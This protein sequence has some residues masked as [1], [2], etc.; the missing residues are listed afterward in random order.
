MWIIYR[1]PDKSEQS[2]LECITNFIASGLST[3][4]TLSPPPQMFQQ[5]ALE[6]QSLY[7]ETWSLI[8]TC[9]IDLESE[10]YYIC[11]GWYITNFSFCFSNWCNN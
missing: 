1:S 10:W 6:F 11:K 5:Y 3:I 9:I 7:I 4:K 2:R 8:P